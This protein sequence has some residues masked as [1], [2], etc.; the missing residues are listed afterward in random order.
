MAIINLY[1]WSWKHQVGG[2]G[3]WSCRQNLRPHQVASLIPSYTSNRFPTD[4]VP[5]IFDNYTATIKID[6]KTVNLGLWD[7]AGQ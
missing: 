6:S 4:Y 1:G 7:T 3:R 2:G 5:T